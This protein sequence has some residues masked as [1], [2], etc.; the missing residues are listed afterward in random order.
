LI[1]LTLREIRRLRR[2]FENTVLK[3]ILG[4]KRQEAEENF[5]MRN[6]M[7]FTVY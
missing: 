1:S 3:R 5:I 4:P 2:V 7:I 6:S